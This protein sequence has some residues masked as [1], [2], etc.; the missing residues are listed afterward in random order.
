MGLSLP[1]PSLLMAAQDVR[2]LEVFC[3]Q[4]PALVA[5]IHFH[6]GGMLALY[7]LGLLGSP[8]VMALC[9][10]LGLSFVWKGEKVTGALGQGQRAHG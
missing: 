1:L 9:S 4:R 8:P 3:L 6:S 7:Y 10:E 2:N 5:F